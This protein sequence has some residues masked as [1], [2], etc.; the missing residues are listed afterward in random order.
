MLEGTCNIATPVPPCRVYANSTAVDPWANATAPGP[1][2]PLNAT[3]DV[4]HSPATLPEAFRLGDFALRV[5]DSRG[6]SSDPAAD[7][8]LD[9]RFRQLGGLCP[10]SVNS[11][12]TNYT[13]WLKAK[14]ILFPFASCAAVP[15]SPAAAFPVSRLP[16]TVAYGLPTAEFLNL[17][18]R[19]VWPSFPCALSRVSWSASSFRLGAVDGDARMWSSGAS[20]STWLYF[21]E[22][23]GDDLAIKLLSLFAGAQAPREDLS[24]VVGA[25]GQALAISA[26]M[27]ATPTTPS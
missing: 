24:F 3:I 20:V 22:A 5:F 27:S 2:V 15:A 9:R 12:L 19:C 1:W 23:P 13:P 17:Q 26:F 14:G 7:I 16:G 4:R 10:D 8:R 21:S 11:F 6:L 25:L 18:S